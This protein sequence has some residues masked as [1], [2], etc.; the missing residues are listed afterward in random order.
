MI[1]L[2][3]ITRK[4]L[5]AAGKNMNNFLKEFGKNE[6]YNINYYLCISYVNKNRAQDLLTTN[7]NDS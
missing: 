5:L 7:D 3:Y 1:I 2:N 6:D 4:S